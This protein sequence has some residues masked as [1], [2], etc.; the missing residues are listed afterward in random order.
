MSSKITDFFEKSTIDS[1][2]RESGFVK[3]ERT[4]SGFDFL[5]TLFFSKFDNSKLS[6]ESLAESF[7]KLSHKEITKQGIDQRFTDQTVLFFKKL[8][9]KFLGDFYSDVPGIEFLK[10]FPEVRIKDSTCFQLPEEMA[11][12]YPG[13]G[14]ASSKAAIRIQFEYDIKTGKVID[15][16]L[17]PF[18]T[19]DSVNAKSTLEDISPNVLLLSD[20]GYVSTHVLKEIKERDAFYICRLKQGASAFF[21]VDGI[22]QKMDFAQ[23]WGHMKNNKLS[24]IEK[25]AYITTELEKVRMIIELLPEEVIKERIRKAEKE[26][27]KKGRKLSK[28]Y[29]SRARLNIFITNIPAKVLD[30]EQIQSVYTLRWQ[31]ELVFKVWKSIGG[32]HKVK[33]MKQERFESYLYAKLL[34]LMLNWMIIWNIH[35]YLYNT[36]KKLL[37]FY[38]AFDSLKE[39]KDDFKSALKCGNKS[40]AHFLYDQIYCSCK[41]HVMEKKKKGNSL[42]NLIKIM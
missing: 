6:L 2:A 21:L 27:K 37:S 34:W 24:K 3:R 5:Q 23:I 14:G 8:I 33:K 15:L 32:I 41:F 38:K 22:Y 40:L 36:H 25:D 26:A 11:D 1:L 35:S 10:S 4:I 16:S 19:Q 31:I 9:E 30:L 7:M 20:L 12:K 39:Y 42:Y 29:K 18:N 28:E 13:S 17:H